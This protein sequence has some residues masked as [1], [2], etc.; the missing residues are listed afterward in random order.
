[1]KWILCMFLVQAT[2]LWAQQWEVKT[3]AIKFEINN[4]GFPVSGSFS[5]LEADIH[6]DPK[7][8]EKGSILASVDATTIDTG[9]DL[10]NKHLKKGDYFDVENY[11]RIS[12]T[13]VSMKK[14]D[15]GAYQGVFKVQIKDLSKEVPISPENIFYVRY[16]RLDFCIKREVH[17]EDHNLCQYHSCLPAPES[18][19][20]Q[21]IGNGSSYMSQA[22]DGCFHD[23]QVFFFNNNSLTLTLIR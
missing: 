16:H 19:D 22:D 17:Q 9:I 7:R 1:M 13:S 11:P 10:R 15:K 18:P 21:G 14:I 5:G 8:P 6:F 3:A 4:A 2:P 23:L 12:M 20:H